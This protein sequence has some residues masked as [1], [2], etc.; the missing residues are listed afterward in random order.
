MTNADSGTGLSPRPLMLTADSGM[1]G[2]VGQSGDDDSNRS[3]K[4]SWDNA[5]R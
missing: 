5:A 4:T 2:R 3:P 1:S